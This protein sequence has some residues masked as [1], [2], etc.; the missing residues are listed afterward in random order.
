MT[1]LIT[2]LARFIL[3]SFVYVVLFQTIELITVL[4]IKLGTFLGRNI[5]PLNR[6]RHTNPL[7]EEK[8]FSSRD[9]V[10]TLPWLTLVVL[11]K[12]LL[13]ISVL[14]FSINLITADFILLSTSI[15]L[16]IIEVLF[17]FDTIFLYNSFRYHIFWKIK[18]VDSGYDWKSYLQ[19]QPLSLKS[20]GFA[21][22]YYR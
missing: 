19:N 14:M 21:R 6:R 17:L 3:A 10:G 5:R 15:C 18:D 8:H 2:I 11:L 13:P 20:I 9:I 12:L 16:V 4:F 1:T 7:K 22:R